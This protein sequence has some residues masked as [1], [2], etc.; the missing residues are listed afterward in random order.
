MDKIIISDLDRTI[1]PAKGKVSTKTINSLKQLKNKG[2][3]RVIATGRSI[4]SA[5]KVLN[6]DFPIDYM[7][8][9]TGAGIIEWK[10]KKLI[11]NKNFTAKTT[12]HIAETLIK[13]NIDFMIFEPIPNNHK[14]K[15]HK[16]SRNNTDFY[17]RFK[18]YMDH[19]TKIE[20]IEDCNIDSC[21]IL[22]IL[23]PES[24]KFNYL[25][26]LFPNANTIRATSPID[27]K[28]IWLELFP[29]EVSKGH[30]S[31]WLMNKLGIKQENSIGVGNDYNDIAFLEIC[32]KSYVVENAPEDLKIVYNTLPKDEEDGFSHIINKL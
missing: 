16:G 4:Y 14:F 25:A 6:E 10:S 7:I 26:S 19:S 12:S 1:L 20:N 13:E 23:P 18:T 27:H 31:L 22:A 8:F 11:Y 29:T 3:I 5:Y 15:W 24:D 17:R 2:Y 21:Q 9:S 30:S 32:N 28:S